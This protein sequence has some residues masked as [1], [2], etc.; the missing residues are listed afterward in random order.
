[1]TKIATACILVVLALC[2]VVLLASAQ[3]SPQALGAPYGVSGYSNQYWR[4]RPP[5][6]G[7][8]C[9]PN[10]VY[11]RCQS[12]SCG[13]RR[14]SELFRRPK[15]PRICTA[16]CVSRCFCRSGFFRN[17]HGR[18]VSRRHCRKP[19]PAPLPFPRS[20]SAGHPE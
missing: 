7:R 9:G 4:P 20:L 11:L 3:A 15:W 1:M 10:Q 14:C 5:Y 2:A 18:C 8:R 19:L 6:P 17:H 12:S 16:D 13:E